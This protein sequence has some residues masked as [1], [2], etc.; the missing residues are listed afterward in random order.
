MLPQIGV[1]YVDTTVAQLSR[2]LRPDLLV[3]HLG[4][5]H[6]YSKFLGK[7]FMETVGAAMETLYS[8]FY[9][10]FR[11]QQVPV[12]SLSVVVPFAVEVHRME[13]AANL[14]IGFLPELAII[15]LGR[16]HAA[17]IL[18]GRGPLERTNLGTVGDRNG[19]RPA[20]LGAILY[21]HGAGFLGLS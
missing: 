10:A 1:C 12:A 8:G 20:P 15:L 17:A 16:D 19:A 6:G 11:A 14:P 5:G 18:Y 9:R 3:Q 21:A 2:N 7:V 4:V 13:T